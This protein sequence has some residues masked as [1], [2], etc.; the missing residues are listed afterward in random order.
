LTDAGIRGWNVK[1]AFDPGGRVSYYTHV[2]IEFSDPPPPA[3]AVA[4]VAKSWLSSQDMYAVEDV[5]SD[6]RE[7]W[8]E[9][10]ADFSDLMS[11]GFEGVM[12]AISARCRNLRMY[13]RGIGEEWHDVWLRQFENGRIVASI[14]PLDDQA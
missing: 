10:K 2:T 11:Q 12:T 9:G 1:V 3:D 14:G 8:T 5:T 6:F 4:R 13:V 7:L